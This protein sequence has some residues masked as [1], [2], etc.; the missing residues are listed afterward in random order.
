L[1]IWIPFIW[2]AG[3]DPKNAKRYLGC[4]DYVTV[5]FL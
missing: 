5:Y 3:E 4:S 1:S 2:N